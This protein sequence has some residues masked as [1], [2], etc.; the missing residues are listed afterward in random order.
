M[1]GHAKV[2]FFK[3]GSVVIFAASLRLKKSQEKNYHE[4][5]RGGI[6]RRHF[7]KAA[8]VHRE[9]STG[10]YG[11]SRSAGTGNFLRR[12]FCMAAR[13]QLR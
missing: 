7:E 8:S 10:K 2:T 3:M 5:R 12:N 9:K 11:A 6:S 4:G 1:A 13:R